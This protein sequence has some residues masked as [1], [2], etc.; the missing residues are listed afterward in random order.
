MGGQFVH[1]HGAVFDE[2]GDLWV[3]SNIDGI[4][5]TQA[6]AI[7][8]GLQ[9]QTIFPPPY[10]DFQSLAGGNVLLDSKGVIVNWGFAGVIEERDFS[11]SAIWKFES[12]IGFGMGFANL[13]P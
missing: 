6:Y 13:A 5:E 4:T 11:G 12:P 2:E 8:Q 1:P 9:L 10:T 7:S 3:L